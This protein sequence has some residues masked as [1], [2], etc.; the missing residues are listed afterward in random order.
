MLRI[1]KASTLVAG[2][3]AIT[4]IMTSSRAAWDIGHDVSKESGLELLVLEV[5]GCIYCHLFRR[6]VAPGY[7]ASER[8]KSV[9]LRYVDLNY[10]SL[11]A[12]QLKA[13]VVEVPTM[14]LVRSRQEVGRISG[15]I[16]PEPFYHAVNRLIATASLSAARPETNDAE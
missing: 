5:E 12:F 13:P 4:A 15:Y 9:P 2:L 16:G 11:D 3:I 14:V 7:Q 8:G 1:V 10:A 6:D